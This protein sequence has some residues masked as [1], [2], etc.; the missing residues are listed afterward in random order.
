MVAVSAPASRAAVPPALLEAP[1]N[2][3]G[4]QEQRI[5]DGF[6]SRA[7]E[8]IADLGTDRFQTIQGDRPAVVHGL[9]MAEQGF[10]ELLRGHVGQAETEQPDGIVVAVLLG[11]QAFEMHGDQAPR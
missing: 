10:A 1:R 2:V 11:H 7:A 3:H 5:I 4:D 8:I 9:E 6:Q